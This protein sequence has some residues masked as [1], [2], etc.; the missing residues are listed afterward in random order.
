MPKF[1]IKI[2]VVLLITA[3]F[4]MTNGFCSEDFFNFETKVAQAS[5]TNN[6]EVCDQ[7]S[8]NQ[9]S[10]NLMGGSPMADH[11]NSVL[12]CCL[13]NG[14]PG[15]TTN[16]QLLDLGKTMSMTLVIKDVLPTVI[17]T[18][19]VYHTPIIDPPELLVVGTTI[20]RL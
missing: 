20:L 4:Q 3:I 16:S 12:P 5:F 6:Q 10:N 13:D 17:S 8:T 7:I 14:R 2:S 15:V 11:H 18:Q 9:A 19:N 1:F